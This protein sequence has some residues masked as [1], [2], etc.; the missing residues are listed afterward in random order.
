VVYRLSVLVSLVRLIVGLLRIFMR[1]VRAGVRL[2]VL[3]S[4]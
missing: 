4:A 1:D 2:S 3:A